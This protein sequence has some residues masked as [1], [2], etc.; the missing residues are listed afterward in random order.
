MFDKKYERLMDDIISESELTKLI[1]EMRHID[2]KAVH[3][4]GWPLKGWV[5]PRE[6]RLPIYVYPDDK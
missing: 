4:I 3:D 2:R 6:F 1:W 5:P